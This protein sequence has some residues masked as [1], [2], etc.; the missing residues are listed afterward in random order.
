M[1]RR[2]NDMSIR[3]KLIVIVAGTVALLTTGV[4][5]SVAI[6]ARHQ[7]NEDVLHEL[8]AARNAFVITEGEHL[9]EH[10]MESEAI[11]RSDFMV[12]LVTARK[13][14]TACAWAE[15]FLAGKRDPIKPEDAFDLVAVVLP[16]GT[17]LAAA[18]NR[19]PSC[20][21]KEMNWR[22]PG[23]SN[24]A[25]RSEVTNWESAA[26]V[27]YE[28]VESPVIDAEGRDLATL[29]VGFEVSDVFA[30]HI[31]DHTR[32][33][34]FLWH[35]EGTK[36]HLLGA[37]GPEFAKLLSRRSG[38]MDSAVPLSGTG[39]KYSILDA[40]IEDKDD[41]VHNPLGLH[42]AL[43]QPLE[44]KYVPFHRLEYS[45]L[46]LACLA[47][48][49]GLA[50]G[51][52]VSR[53][54]ARPLASLAAAAENVAEGKL[55][56]AD[57]L[58]RKNPQ[59]MGAKDEIGVLGRSFLRMVQGLKER[60]AMSTFLSQATF[61]HIRR[62][63]EGHSTSGRTSLA[64]LF[65]DV[66]Q[67]SNFAE[68][69]DP[70][71]VIQLLNQVLSIEAD[72]VKK[73][74][75]DIDKFVGDEVVAWFSG[76]DRCQRAVRAGNEMIASLQSRFNGQPG[77]TIGV[78]IHVGEVVVGSIGSAERRDYT[79][80][81]STVNLAA[82]LCASAHAGQ[83]LVSQAVAKELGDQADLKPL[84]PIP[85]KGFSGPVPVFEANSNA[86]AGE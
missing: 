60:L 65:A 41:I 50:L 61:E 43:V 48:V 77:T 16:G 27:F 28:L 10:V 78:G 3:N 69:R 46:L 74:G 63:T 72:T 75:G 18:R 51:V 55:D 58:M 31:K 66:R 34:T 56:V 85:L 20:T 44:E 9:H 70:E 17:P 53:P 39:E 67:F 24:N 82:R 7:V 32:Q 71:V 19:G 47:L 57:G 80:I 4:L 42:V 8:E 35:I 26:G 49:L 86:T 38:G 54:I 11:A 79:A 14:W 83:I 59:R 62:D 33:D 1:F 52:V 36:P 13:S 23:L 6:S 40:T 73:H 12:D 15:D 25:N 68:T 37:S 30:H 5:L 2:F 81:G 76:P 21:E 84:T 22:L 29:I 64:I 45:L